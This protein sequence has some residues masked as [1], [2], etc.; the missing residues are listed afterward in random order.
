MR[1]NGRSHLR[2]SAGKGLSVGI[3]KRNTR[4]LCSHGNR[5]GGGVS[6]L[7]LP[8]SGTRR[9]RRL[10]PQRFPRRDYRGRGRLGRGRRFCL[11]AHARA[12][13][14]GAASCRSIGRR[15]LRSAKRI[16]ASRRAGS[17]S[18]APPSL[19][20]T[21]RPARIALRECAIPRDRRY[22]YPFINCTNCGPRYSHYRRH[23]VRPAQYHDEVLPDVP[24]LSGRVRRPGVEALPRA[25]QRLP[26]VRPAPL[27]RGRGGQSGRSRTTRL[28]TR[29][30][31]LAAGDV[32]AVKGLGGFHL[33][34]DAS[35][36][37]GRQA[38][39]G[40]QAPRGKGVCRHAAGHGRRACRGGNDAGG[41]G[42]AYGHPAADSAT[43]EAAGRSACRVGRAEVK[44]LWR[45]ASVHAASSSAHGRAALRRL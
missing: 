21:A 19:R 4:S 32:V 12:A 35:K 1:M 36:R 40:A 30:E 7:H 2:P 26:R 41:A 34:V 15:F 29:I 23:P 24:L 9:P 28:R 18:R 14:A 31:R 42:D 45:D 13:A 38:P 33:A 39:A 6:A 25:T 27:R 44:V 8:D 20:P 22:R 43:A 10:R 16:S 17:S 5:P 37:V 3:G 11:G